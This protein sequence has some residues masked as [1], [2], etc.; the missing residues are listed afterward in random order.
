M[1][2][3]LPACGAG[4]SAGDLDGRLD[5]RV[6]L[7]GADPAGRGAERLSHAASSA[8]PFPAGA[9]HRLQP[10]HPAARL[11]GHGGRGQGDRGLRPVCGG[12]Q[13]RGRLRAVSGPDRHSILSGLS[14]RGAH[15]RGDRALH[16]GCAAGQADGHRRGHEC[17]A[18]RRGGGA[19]AAAGHCPRGRVLRR[20]G[21]SGALQPAR[22]AG[23]DPD[24]GHQHRCRAC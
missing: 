24:Y 14:R 21:W 10:P 22:L 8:D 2:V 18:D 5:H 9:E 6:S 19:Q 7:R 3:P 4:F 15:R 20:H 16:P 1:L 11:R 12:R 17:R 13:L 23:H